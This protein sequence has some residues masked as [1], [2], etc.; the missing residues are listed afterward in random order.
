MK[1][2]S[3]AFPIAELMPAILEM[4]KEYYEK[5]KD[6]LNRFNPKDVNVLNNNFS[7]EF[8][9]KEILDKLAIT[10][11]CCRARVLEYCNFY[12]TCLN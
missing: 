1:C 9:M 11:V 3:C 8:S 6:K 7:S 10:D 12:E 4:K 5:N 2:P